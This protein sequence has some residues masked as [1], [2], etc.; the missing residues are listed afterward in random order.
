MTSG[1]FSKVQ[2]FSL[3]VQKERTAALKKDSGLSLYITEKHGD[4]RKQCSPKTA[5]N[6]ICCRFMWLSFAI[7]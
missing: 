2:I 5:D 3:E 4:S 7:D 6:Y 1:A